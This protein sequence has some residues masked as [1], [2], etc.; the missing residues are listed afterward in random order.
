MTKTYKDPD[1]GNIIL[2]KNI[3]STRINIKIHPEKGVSI[4]LP[5][6]STYKNAIDF[7]CKKKSIILKTLAS[8]KEK[9]AGRE[10]NKLGVNEQAEII[11]MA[12]KNLPIKVATIAGKLGLNYNNVRIKDNKT[13][14][15]SC[16]SKSNIN[17]NFRLLLVDE[18]LC[19]FVILHELTHLTHANHGREFHILQ[20]K[21][22]SIH[23]PFLEYGQGKEQ[24]QEHAAFL[25]ELRVKI[26]KSR[27]EF[28]ISHT[29]HLELKKQARELF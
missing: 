28:P 17:L 5:Y 12:K 11:A 9:Q 21:Y 1:I 6:F 13:N 2:R 8:L 4:T 14:W 26:K 20:E 27:S 3:R 24:G 29:L 25:S 16:S 22:C 19:D 23:F 15:G 7:F 10:K 18:I